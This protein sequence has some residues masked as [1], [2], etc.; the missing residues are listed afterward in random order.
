MNGA[1]RKAEIKRLRAAFE[2]ELSLT[3]IEPLET[4]FEEYLD[5]IQKMI[6]EFKEK[7]KKL[8]HWRKNEYET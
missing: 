7:N 4:N 5:E 6:D 1:A 8:N 2:F 3:A